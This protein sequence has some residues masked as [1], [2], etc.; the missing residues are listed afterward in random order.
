MGAC[1]WARRPPQ[2]PH[3]DLPPALAAPSQPTW[4]LQ[5]V[6]IVDVLRRAGITVTLA[7]IEPGRPAVTCS[8]GVTLIADTL[9]PDAA[10]HAPYDAVIL[11]GGMLGAARLRDCAALTAVVQD[12]HAAGRLVAAICAAPAV[13]LQPA[14]VLTG[15][16][17]TAHPAFV[18]DLEDASSADARVVIDGHV[19]TSRGPGTAFEF[20]LALVSAL[21]GADAAAEVAGPMVLGAAPAPVVV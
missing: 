1:D 11:P 8:R 14:G 17:A 18:K 5:A 19:V 15:R 13:A 6:I 20:S 9:L 4:V 12:Q 3:V 7:S 10:T 21:C 2:P 16:K